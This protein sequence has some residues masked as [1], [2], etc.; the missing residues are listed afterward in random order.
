[1]SDFAFDD[2][3]PSRYRRSSPGPSWLH[4]FSAVFAG[5]LLAGILLLVGLR[6]YL[7]WSIEDGIE[8]MK[9]PPSAKGG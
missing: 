3:S 2:E 5:A 4:T 9:N 8:R 7:K 6:A 1:M